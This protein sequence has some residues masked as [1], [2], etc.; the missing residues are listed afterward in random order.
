MQNSQKNANRNNIPNSSLSVLSL[1]D[2]FWTGHA[3][4][5][6]DVEVEAMITGGETGTKTP[7]VAPEALTAT[8]DVF[9][10]EVLAEGELATAAENPAAIAEEPVVAVG[11]VL[12]TAAGLVVAETPL[13]SSPSTLESLLDQSSDIVLT[14]ATSLHAQKTVQNCNK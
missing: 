7:P 14:K 1:G 11:L 10:V 3:A 8:P 12:E 2:L 13:L 4:A 9:T 5:A 6:A